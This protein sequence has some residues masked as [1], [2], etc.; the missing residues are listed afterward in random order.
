M[1]GLK[2]IFLEYFILPGFPLTPFWK[3]E[4]EENV[5]F[6]YIVGLH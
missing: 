1:G 6:P 2:W 5:T 3:F 4:T